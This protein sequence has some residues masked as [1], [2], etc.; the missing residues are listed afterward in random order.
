[1]SA[2]WD[3]K[4]KKSHKEK[5]FNIYVKQ[6]FYLNYSGFHI[7]VNEVYQVTSPLNI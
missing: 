4:I 6:H 5:T 7:H 1:M 2:V 3:N